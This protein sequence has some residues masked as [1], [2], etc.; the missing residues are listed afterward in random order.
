MDLRKWRP[1]VTILLSSV[2]VAACGGA[3]ATEPVETMDTL[4]ST[5]WLNAHLDDPDLVILDCSV[6]LDRNDSGGFELVPGRADY[7]AAHVPGAGFADLLGDLSDADS[8]LRFA[9]PPPAEFAQA[10]AA[11]GVGDGSRVVL[12]DMGNSAW[13]ARVWWMLRWIGF[14]RAAILDGGF[15]AWTDEAR[16]VSTEIPSPETGTLTVNLRPEL[17]A[18]REDVLAAIEDPEVTIID[19]LPEASYRG[20]MKMYARPGHIATAVNVPADD[21]VDDSGHYRPLEELRGLFPESTANGVITYCGG[22]IAAST[23]AFA[24]HRL[25]FNK[26]AV[27]TASLQEWTADDSLPMETVDLEP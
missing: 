15:K 12:Y 18:G 1:A 6:R 23:T 3:P 5:D 24:L 19:A 21:L 14:D 11:L 25:G 7:E 16:P 13:A 10:M 4:V 22:G 20:E 17:V 8:P 2:L 27:Y 26:V 9:V